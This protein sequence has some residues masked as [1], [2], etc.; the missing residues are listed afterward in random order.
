MKLTLAKL[1][2]LI[3]TA[4]DAQFY[5]ASLQKVET[6]DLSNSGI[7]GDG[8][9]DVQLTKLLYFVSLS[10]EPL[11]LSSLDLSGNSLGDAGAKA[12]GELLQTNAD[13]FPA[14]T[15]LDV[16]Q[17]GIGDDGVLALMRAVEAAVASGDLAKLADVALD[18]NAI[19]ETT[20]R[21]IDAIRAK[22]PAVHLLSWRH[23]TLPAESPDARFGD[24]LK[25][26]MQLVLDERLA[27]TGKELEPIVTLLKRVLWQFVSSD[28]KLFAGDTLKLRVFCLPTEA[29]L[30]KIP[31][32]LDLHHTEV[33]HTRSPIA[34]FLQQ[35]PMLQELVKIIKPERMKALQHMRQHALKANDPD[36]L[37]LP[38]ARYTAN[39]DQDTLATLEEHYAA[40]HDAVKAADRLIEEFNAADLNR[41]DLKSMALT[42]AVGL[43]V[44]LTPSDR[45]WRTAPSE[46]NRAIEGGRFIKVFVDN[47]PILSEG[48][49]YLNPNNPPPNFNPHF[50]KFYPESGFELRIDL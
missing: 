8:V 33:F 31:P 19:S 15:A 3:T 34:S 36:G 40:M 18:G 35:S 43:R 2:P 48:V 41:A 42:R 38:L 23:A 20:M 5:L 37:L 25:K 39:I 50:N 47:K 17:N 30:N 10:E 4:L 45:H 21:L 14:L 26:E 16:S 22:F 28:R 27:A 29:D 24:M 32:P 9:G 7:V 12:L 44:K 13:K 6:L 11:A 1:L 46:E 49:H